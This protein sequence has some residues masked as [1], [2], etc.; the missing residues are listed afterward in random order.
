LCVYPVLG[1][2]ATRLSYEA[3]LNN[4][5]DQEVNGG[6]FS[7][8]ESNRAY[9]GTVIPVLSV[10]YK[11]GQSCPEQLG[12]EEGTRT[13]TPLRVHGPEP[14]ASANSATSARKV[15]RR[16]RWTAAIASVTKASTRVKPCAPARHFYRKSSSMTLPVQP[17]SIPEQQ[18]KEIRRISH[19]LS[20]ALEV[21]LQ[22]SFLLGTIPLDDDA[23][24][25][26]TMLENGVQ[27]AADLN[28]QLREYVRGN[29]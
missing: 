28:R 18:A 14:C 26:R 15:L 20:N 17:K 2:T 5:T 10:I 12:A 22:T 3:L 25:W 24:K 19:D 23:K 27:Q 21:V 13:P 16:T 1:F 4:P 7:G 6:F 9:H 8:A 11:K 29:S